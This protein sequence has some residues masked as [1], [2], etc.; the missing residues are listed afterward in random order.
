ME[1]RNLAKSPRLPKT[2]QYSTMARALADADRADLGL[3]V[4]R[5]GEN[6]VSP[7]N[8]TMYAWRSAVALRGVSLEQAAA[9]K[10]VPARGL[11]SLVNIHVG[12]PPVELDASLY[13]LA[14]AVT[15]GLAARLTARL[16]RHF[17]APEA[18]FRARSEERR[19]GEECRSRWA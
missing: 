10:E 6:T 5:N 16:L 2:L 11:D 12:S 7:I 18:V 4:R 3:A 13:W 17:S 19:V 15:P 1:M 8:R 9:R 14:L